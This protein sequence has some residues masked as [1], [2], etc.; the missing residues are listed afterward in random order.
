MGITAPASQRLSVVVAVRDEAANIPPLVAGLLAVAPELDASLEILLVDDGSTDDTWAAVRAAAAAHPEVRGLRLARNCGQQRALVH[1][2][3]TASGDAVVTMDGDL[4]HPPELIPRLVAAWRAG[5]RV[6]HTERRGGTGGWFK[7]SAARLF[8]GLFTRLAGFRLPPGSSDFRLLDRA[9]VTAVLGREDRQ[10]FLRGAA[11]WVGGPEATVPFVA[12]PRR[13]GSSKYGLGNQLRLAA[14]GIL[15]YSTRPLRLGIWAGLATSA[16]AF[17]EIGYVL[18]RHLSGRT[19]PGWASILIVVSFM[20]GIL[21]LLLGILGSY[22]ASLHER[23]QP[24]PPDPVAEDT[25][26]RLDGRPHGRP[27]R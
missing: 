11:R 10:P 13:H 6:V 17:A 20:F 9:A 27:L 15:A 12:P 3:A 25:G 14:A 21:F 4:Q 19:V 26:S 22:L 2:L 23:L 7:R 24:R 16:L 1:G 5:A 18:L 8:Y